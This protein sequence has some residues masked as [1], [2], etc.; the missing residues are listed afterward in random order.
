MLPEPVS[1]VQQPFGCK[2]DQ[3]TDEDTAPCRGFAS[4]QL[5]CLPESNPRRKLGKQQQF[6]FRSMK[7]YRFLLRNYG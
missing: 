1:T 2:Q 6:R 4:S 5:T 7:T 3:M